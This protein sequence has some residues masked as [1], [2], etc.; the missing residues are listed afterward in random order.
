MGLTISP[1]VIGSFK[2]AK[3]YKSH[4]EHGRYFTSIDFDDKGEYLVTAGEDEKLQLFSCRTGKHHKQLYSKKYGVHLARFAHT[5]ST[6]VYASTKEDDTIRYLS[7]HDNSFLR[8]FKG[9]KRRVTSLEV[10][11]VDD[12]FLSG[13]MDDT[14]RVWDLRADKCQGLLNIAGN[15]CVAFDHG[16]ICFGVA[17]NLKST[18]LLYDMRGYDKEPFQ[19]FHLDD[20]AAAN[21]TGGY[22]TFTSLKF[23]ADGTQLLIGTTGN[24]HFIMDAFSGKTTH[25]VTGHLGLEPASA[26][27]TP[28]DPSLGM[29]GS[30]VSWT[31]DGRF[32]IGGSADGKVH[33]WD[34][35]QQN[36]VTGEINTLT[37]IK[38]FEGHAGSPSRVVSFNPKLAMFASA[39]KELAL[40]L[41]DARGMGS[42][43]H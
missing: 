21:L 18:V 35:Q 28:Y 8:Y 12:T 6:V 37:P 5:S 14:V 3:L 13:A 33:V 29:S 39:G 15:P 7:L 16:G 19:T 31:P 43:I 23:S 38:T 4:V 40:W 42:G 2:I 17:L 32:V 34:T 25:R 27:A 30:E 36:S 1:D 22:P 26:A 41:P 11:P 9:H 10:S 24:V 20:P